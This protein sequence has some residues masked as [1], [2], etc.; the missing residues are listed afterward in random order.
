MWT[1][2]PFPFRQVEVNR[3]LSDRFPTSWSVHRGHH[4][5]LW[6][7]TLPALEASALPP[8]PD[9]DEVLSSTKSVTEKR[10]DRHGAQPRSSTSRTGDAGASGAGVGGGCGRSDSSSNSSSTRGGADGTRAGG[11][12][13]QGKGRRGGHTKFRFPFLA[14]MGMFGRKEKSTPPQHAA[15]CANELEP[16]DTTIEMA[17]ATTAAEAAPGEGGDAIRNTRSSREPCLEAGSGTGGSS[18]GGG[19]NNN[20][21]NNKDPPKTA[22]LDAVDPRS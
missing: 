3:S 9:D 5:F 8:L 18:S 13:A 16:A 22:R 1:N 21:N 17:E 12:G 15:V 14:C 11:G 2:V 19:N 6:N 20:N 7:K 10:R 4:F